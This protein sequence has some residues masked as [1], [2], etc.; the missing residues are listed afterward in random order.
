MSRAKDVLQDQLLANANDPSWYVSFSESVVNLTEEEAFW[1]PNDESNSIAEIVQHLLYWNETWQT[2]Y[3]ES[4]V[5]AVA[6]INDNNES[7]VIP[8]NIT[9]AALKKSLLAVLLQWQDLLTQEK[10]DND[11][12]GFPETAKWWEVLSNLT[13][14]NAYHIGQIVYIRKLQKSWKTNLKG[15]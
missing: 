10:V 4:H 1:K 3:K 6:P 15:D 8:E 14:H 12:I 9:F 13:T 5:N 7:F 11:V 2:R